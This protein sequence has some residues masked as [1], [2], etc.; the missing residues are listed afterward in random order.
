MVL[1]VVK[2]VVLIGGSSICNGSDGVGS[3]RISDSCRFSGRGAVS[4]S[5]IGDS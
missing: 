3:S 2:L 4:S 1:G 5:G